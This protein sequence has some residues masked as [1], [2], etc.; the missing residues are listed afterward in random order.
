VE[1]SVISALSFVRGTHREDVAIIEAHE[2][3]LARHLARLDLS[4]QH[5]LTCVRHV[6]SILLSELFSAASAKANA[7]HTEILHEVTMRASSYFDLTASAIVDEYLAER[8]RAES[9]ALL[10]RRRLVRALVGGEDVSPVDAQRVLGLELSAHHLAAILW[11][12][13]QVAADP[14][15]DLG[16]ERV[17]AKIAGALRAQSVLTVPDDPGG[18]LLCWFTRSGA[19]PGPTAATINRVVGPD[20][21]VRMAIGPASAGPLGFRR[22]HLCARAAERVA[23]MGAASG[24]VDY[25]SY[26]AVALLVNDDEK[27]R[28]FVEDELGL[29]ASDEDPSHSDLRRTAKCYLDCGRSLVKTAATLH[30]HRNTVLYRLERA[31][32][33]LGRDI[34]DRPLSTHAALTLAAVLGSTG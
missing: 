15:K 21:N 2:V 28:W 30:V 26:A 14:V 10:G 13:D 22:S 32:R 18:A 12:E 6:Q 24:A 17:A 3:S 20:D 29:L 8:D 4:Y 23:R 1:I 11:A 27:A 9:Q 16:L 7:C 19:F 34:G 5:L 33:L 25:L 31:Q